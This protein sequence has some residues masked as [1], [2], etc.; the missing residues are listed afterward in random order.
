MNNLNFP[1]KFTPSFH[2]RIWGGELLKEKLNKNISE[3]NIGESWEIS[4]VPNFCSVV[5]KGTLKGKNLSELIELFQEKLLGTYVFEKYGKEFPLL[6][7]FIDAK[8]K[9]SIQVHPDDEYALKKHQSFG[10]N[11]MWYILDSQEDSDLTIGFNQK[12]TKNQVA[13]S[14]QNSKITSLL[15]EIHPKPSEIYY[16]PAG[17]VHAIGK[18]VLLAEIQQT[19]DVTYRVYDYDRIDKDGKKR[20][21]HLDAALEVMNYSKLEK[22][23]TEYEEKRNE[24]NLIQKTPFF[25]TY[26]LSFNKRFSINFSEDSFTILIQTKGNSKLIINDEEEELK[27]GETLLI[28]ACLTSYQIDTLTDSELLLVR[29]ERD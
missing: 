4:T 20:E 1:I 10:K 26:K 9:L 28:P 11:E 16:L 29:V 18:N 14:L 22:A 3:N 5:E 24:L 21:L 23:N 8:E 25:N 6:I 19:S 17:R 13:E 15:N 7:K 27:F 12:V 2:Y